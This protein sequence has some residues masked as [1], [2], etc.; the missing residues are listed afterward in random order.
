ML[1]IKNSPP[2]QRCK[3]AGLSNEILLAIIIIKDIYNIFDLYPTI[4][5][6]TDGKHGITSL[7]YKGKAL[8]I[9]LPEKNIAAVFNKIAEILGPDYDVVLESTHIHIEFDPKS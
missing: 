7:H 4:T 5:S 1:H 2:E 8:D 3:V 9:R 6:I